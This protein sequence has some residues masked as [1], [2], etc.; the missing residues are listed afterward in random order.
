MAYKAVP[1]VSQKRR[2]LIKF[3]HASSIGVVGP[4]FYSPKIYIAPWAT[5][6]RNLPNPESRLLD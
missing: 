3:A 5:L 6:I 1:L 4:F 2:V